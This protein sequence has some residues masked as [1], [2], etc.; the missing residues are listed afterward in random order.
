LEKSDVKPAVSG[1]AMMHKSAMTQKL[2]LA[3]EA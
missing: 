1:I 2:A 3:N